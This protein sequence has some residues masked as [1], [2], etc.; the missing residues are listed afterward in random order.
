M[1]A[2]AA[3]A[4]C[5]S[6]PAP[7]R[8][9]RIEASLARIEARLDRHEV[10]RAGRPGPD[11]T[12]TGQGTIGKLLHDDELYNNL[13]SITQALQNGK[14]TLG[15]LLHDPELERRLRSRGDDEPRRKK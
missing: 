11:R 1:V 6:A 7:D 15:R 13:K 4:G 14:G 3:L 2:V 10:E 5:T 8:L 12:E 9:A